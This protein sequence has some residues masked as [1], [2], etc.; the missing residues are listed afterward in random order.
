MP[1]GSCQGTVSEVLFTDCVRRRPS[2]KIVSCL[3]RK[4]TNCPSF[5]RRVL[6]MTFGSR[7]VCAALLLAACV[8]CAPLMAGNPSAGRRA[9]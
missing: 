2:L 4:Q 9:R 6:V 3:V 5:P 1:I 8:I 7:T